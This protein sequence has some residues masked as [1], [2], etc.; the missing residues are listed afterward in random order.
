MQSH[1]FSDVY[2]LDDNVYCNDDVVICRF[3]K[4]VI[5]YFKTQ[6]VFSFYLLKKSKGSNVSTTIMSLLNAENP[7]PTLRMLIGTGPPDPLSCQVEEYE[8]KL[9]PQCLG[10]FDIVISFETRQSLMT[11]RACI[12]FVN[13]YANAD[14]VELFRL[15]SS[16]V[17]PNM[18]AKT[19]LVSR[20]KN[21]FENFPSQTI[22]LL[23]P[24]SLTKNV[25]HIHTEAHDL[26]IHV[27]H[28]RS[29]FKPLYPG[30]NF[31][32]VYLDED[33]GLVEPLLPQTNSI[34]P[35]FIV[36]KLNSLHG[37]FQ[38]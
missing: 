28:K 25:G 6:N 18:Y 21:V 32:V 19:D 23:S 11:P 26:T 35:H 27:V 8:I 9:I 2:H 7:E 15:L 30:M 3:Y 34:Q 33:R 24:Q 14:P 37:L 12:V 36:K 31:T 22:L 5:V 10:S 29:F 13:E 20:L 1:F 4:L 16:P 38:H 17:S